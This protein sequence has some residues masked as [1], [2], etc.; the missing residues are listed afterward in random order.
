MAYD[1]PN[2]G[3]TTKICIG[4]IGDSFLRE[5]V[6]QNAEEGTCSY[7][8]RDDRVI[9]LQDLADRIHEV[10]EAQ[11][12]VTSSEPEGFD[13]YL[14]E[15]GRWDRPGDP[16]AQIISDIAGLDEEVSEDIREKGQRRRTGLLG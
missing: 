13:Y 4:C 1:H 14:A 10:L 11:F 3:E 9:S 15:E 8:L 7:C 12:Y 6:R 16:V 2:D 5:E